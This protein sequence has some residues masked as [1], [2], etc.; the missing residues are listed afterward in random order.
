VEQVGNLSKF[1]DP[2]L[3]DASQCPMLTLDTASPYVIDF[4]GDKAGQRAHYM[5]RWVSTRGDKG[6]WSE[7]ASATIWA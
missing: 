7:T 2:A 3:T 4:D 5:L 6:L 1:A